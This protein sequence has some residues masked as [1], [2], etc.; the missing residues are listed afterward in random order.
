[1]SVLLDGMTAPIRPDDG[2][3]SIGLLPGSHSVRIDWETPL[4]VGLNVRPAAVDMHAS[5][6][7]VATTI[8][9]PRDRWPLFATGAGVGP[10]FLYWSELAVFVVVAVLLGRWP[11]SPLRTH[12]WL[13]LGFGLSTLS[14]GVLV[15]VAAWLFALEWRQRWAG[16]L[17]EEPTGGFVERIGGDEVAVARWRF[18]AIQVLLAVLTV[19][20]VGALVFSGIRQSL[21]ASPDMGV[22]GPGSG[23]TSFAW[24][25][26]RTGSALP[27][28]R[29]ISLPMWA[30]RAVMFAWA[31]WLVLALLRWLRWAWQ[32]WKTNGIWRGPAEPA[33]AT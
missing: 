7:N 21:L 19:V 26:D 30:Y 24:F 12:E 15:L 9:L 4:G 11:R 22:T 28:P 13:L 5:A 27:E 2:A 8:S 16:A 3:L 23:G 17:A 31:L 14:W 32:A 29:V 10:A 25:L 1:M 20:A 33:T 6:S 18:N